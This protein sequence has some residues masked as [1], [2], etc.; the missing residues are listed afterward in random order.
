LG[1]AEEV[2]VAAGGKEVLVDE[3]VRVIVRVLV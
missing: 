3:A 2:D 1:V